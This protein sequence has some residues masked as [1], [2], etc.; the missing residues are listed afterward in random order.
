MNGFPSGQTGQ[1]Y[2]ALLIEKRDLPLGEKGK[3]Y[4][5]IQG[6]IEGEDEEPGKG[7]EAE[8]S[9]ILLMDASDKGHKS[10]KRPK[11]AGPSDILEVDPGVV[12]A[13]EPGV[14]EAAGPVLMDAAGKEEPKQEKEEANRKPYT[15]ILIE[16]VPVGF[17][18]E[19]ISKARHEY[20]I[21]YVNVC[22]L[23]GEACNKS[24]SVRL[25]SRLAGKTNPHNGARA[26]MG[27][28]LEAG[29]EM[30]GPAHDAREPSEAQVLA[31]G[32]EHGLL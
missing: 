10:V 12:G 20:A 16:G 27:A 32:K 3:D 4:T 28:W 17:K 5:R 30:S 1:Y 26:F 8:T 2:R 29:L 13:A 15:K 22:T 9:G 18:H 23:H 19:Y 14:E 7:G 11:L 31:Y 6:E 24:R 25:D 21:L